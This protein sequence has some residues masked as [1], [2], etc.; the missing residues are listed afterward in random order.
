[1]FTLTLNYNVCITLLR[2]VKTDANSIFH[3]IDYKI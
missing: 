2:P 1:L 3:S